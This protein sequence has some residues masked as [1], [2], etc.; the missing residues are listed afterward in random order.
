MFFSSFD[1]KVLLHAFCIGFGL[2]DDGPP[3]GHRDM[4]VDTLRDPDVAEKGHPESIPEL[5]LE[6]AG[7]V[8]EIA[9]GRGEK[10]GERRSIRQCPEDART[11]NDRLS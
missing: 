10:E 7:F 8:M 11:P 6:A 3:M 4:S 5:D 9:G 1:F 2:P